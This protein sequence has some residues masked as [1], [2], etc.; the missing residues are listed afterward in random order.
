MTFDC[1]SF[2][3]CKASSS[4]HYPITTCVIGCHSKICAY[5]NAV[6]CQETFSSQRFFQGSVKADPEEF[7][8]VM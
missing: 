2:L 1:F 7:L 5:I 8:L 6:Y 4:D 3:A